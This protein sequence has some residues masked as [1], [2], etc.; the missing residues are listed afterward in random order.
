MRYIFLHFHLYFFLQKNI[1]FHIKT[2]FS[3]NNVYFVKNTNIFSKKK[4]FFNLVLQQMNNHRRKL[5]V[6]YVIK[7]IMKFKYKNRKNRSLFQIINSIKT[8]L[9]KKRSFCFHDTLNT[10]WD[11]HS[12]KALS[13]DVSKR[14]TLIDNML[15]DHNFE[16]HW[17][18]DFRMSL[19]TFRD[20][21]R[22]VQ[23]ALGK[24]DTQFRRAIPIE[25]RVAIAL[26]RLST[27]N[28]FQRLFKLLESFIQKCCV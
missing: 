8:Y 26:W 27:G 4:F 19:D 23:P 10:F 3:A 5:L 22:V 20:I 13:V 1:F 24:R 25:K 17:R 12:Q 14:R 18:S 11:E 9:Q 15:N 21:V 6:M 28:S 2:F 7:R 16:Q